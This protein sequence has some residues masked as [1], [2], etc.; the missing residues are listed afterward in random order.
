MRSRI[1]LYGAAVLVLLLALFL[2]FQELGL[3]DHEPLNSAAS[4]PAG[5]P[6]EYNGAL[7]AHT[8][9]S[10]G[11]GSLEEVASAADSLGLDF[12]VI[13][14]HNTLDGRELE[15]RRGSCTVLVGSEI[16]TDDGHV[17]AFG[18]PETPYRLGGDGA[19]TIS[20]V[21]ELGGM[22]V[23]AHPVND[24][25]GWSSPVRVRADGIEIFN[26]DSLWRNAPIWK[27]LFGS[28]A[29]LVNPSRTML[30]VMDDARQERHQWDAYL[31][32]GPIT[33][34]AG[35]DAHGTIRLGG[36]DFR[37]PRYEDSLAWFPVHILTDT[38]L[39]GKIGLDKRVIQDALKRG[40]CYLSLGAIGPVSGFRFNAVS[41]DPAQRVGMGRS[42]TSDGRVTLVAELSA[43]KPVKIVLLKNGAVVKENWGGRLEYASASP[44]VYRAEVYAGES[45]SLA[46]RVPWVLSNPIRVNSPGRPLELPVL[47]DCG[48]GRTLADFEGADV[49]LL[50]LRL[51]ADPVTAG[52]AGPIEVASPG[53]RGT[54]QSLV[55][56]F[57]FPP[58][59]IPEAE[60]FWALAD[61]Q[62]RNLKGSQG[63]SFYVRSDKRF[64]FRFE[65]RE[66][67]EAGLMGEEYFTKTFLTTPDWRCVDIPF[68]KLRCIAKGGDGKLDP[69]KVSGI[70]FV[71]DTSV[72]KLQAAGTLWLDEVRAYPHG[73]TP[74]MIPG[75]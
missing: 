67:D 21:R 31:E 66:T 68:D 18:I 52:A 69:T 45:G 16:S 13:T 39:T 22:S 36:W 11:T 64:R 62:A 57:A 10:D 28:A 46:G 54:R 26:A 38:E 60:R 75:N 9:L 70:Y 20:D 71:A 6:Y 73:R 56:P 59:A 58:A 55:V 14:D 74:H 5:P 37:F 24:Q 51:E 30:L 65:I 34:L 47:R 53:A 35:A 1:T 50:Q 23:I 25:N 8:N 27:L 4:L 7:H 33:G 40:S 63:I 72:L 32:T 3:L 15:G 17:L 42:L 2:G 44:G 29:F 19:E 12:V 61:R 43:E 48:P 49:D 41:N